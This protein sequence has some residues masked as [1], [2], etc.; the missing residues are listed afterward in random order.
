MLETKKLFGF[1]LSYTEL[2]KI[3]VASGAV[4]VF[5]AYEHA[6]VKPFLQ[7]FPAGDCTPYAL[8]VQTSLGERIAFAGLKFS[9][10]P[11]KVWKLALFDEHDVIKLAQESDS[12]VSAV[13]SGI[14]CVGDFVAMREYDALVKSSI[15]DYHVMDMAVSFDGN[16]AFVYR[17][18]G[19]PALGVF[20]S[21]WGDGS[22]PAYIGL[23][24]N[25]SPVNIICDF[26][27]I[28][29]PKPAEKP[30]KTLSFAFDINI[31]QIYRND[32]RLSVDENNIAKWSFVIENESEVDNLTLYKAYSRR[33]N[34]YHNIGKLEAALADYYKALAIA[35][36]SEK[37]G[38]FRTREWTLYDNAGAINKELGNTAEAKRLFEKARSVGDSFYSG[39]Y[40]N[41]IDL[42]AEEKNYE[43]ALSVA[44]EMVRDR[45]GDPNAY[46]K[47]AELYAAL[48]NYEKAIENYDVLIDRFAWQ[49]GILEK[50]SCL[51]MM[52]RYDEALESLEAYAV[53]NK[54]N[55]FYYYN[56]GFLEYKRRNYRRSY[57]SLLKAFEYNSEFLPTVHLLIEIDD[58]M[59]NNQML[60]KWADKYVEL[61]P[62]SEF[63]YNVRAGALLKTRNAAAAVKD[64][65]YIID[66]ISDAPVYA[67]ALVCAHLQNRDFSRAQKAVKRLRRQGVAP[68][69][70]NDAAGLVYT[71]KGKFAKA[72]KHLT[73]ALDAAETE[74][75]FS[76]LCALY[77]ACGDRQKA[78]AVLERFQNEFPSSDRY[79]ACA[80]AL[81][82]K[83]GDS[84]RFNSLVNDYVSAALPALDDPEMLKN[85]AASL[86]TSPLI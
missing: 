3:P 60:V 38:D 24:E 56:L 64:I 61:R 78:A 85:I 86:K 50:V 16:T 32:P 36:Q 43:K 62:Q 30:S 26:N 65:E 5:D 29:Y 20:S 74:E 81:A 68:D 48:E 41:L 76:D 42:Y 83:T 44:A 22:Y 49:E 67:R 18:G 35:E 23:D 79:I 69:V 51:L 75:H 15:D 2:E 9:D 40:L 33:G 73:A 8:S 72:E 46:M 21:G 34:S 27:M 80:A 58:L 37:S 6:G 77:T 54:T 59:M 11:A 13:N 28:E 66:N 53:E 47:S 52:S 31:E 45:P 84:D 71:A 55:E 82:L 63:G 70:Y 1:A 25:G 39:A 4:C 17:I 14:V 57:E 10:K 7:K 12:V 19:A